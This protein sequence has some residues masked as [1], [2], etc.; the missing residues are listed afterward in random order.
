M[1]KKS[2]INILTF[3]VF[4]MTVNGQKV[5]NWSQGLTYDDFYHS[6]KLVRPKMRISN[7]TLYVCMASGMYFN[8]LQNSSSFFL[9]GFHELP[10]LDFA[11]YDNQLIVLPSRTTGQTD[12]LLLVSSNHGITFQDRTPSIEPKDSLLT[13]TGLGQNPLNPESLLLATNKGVYMSHDFGCKWTKCFDSIL[14]EPVLKYHPLDTTVIFLSGKSPKLNKAVINRINTSTGETSFYCMSENGSQITDL[15]FNAEDST[16]IW[17]ACNGKDPIGKSQDGG[18]TWQSSKSNAMV[19]LS[20][21]S[22]Y[23]RLWGSE[24][25][26]DT[27][28]TATGTSNSEVY[29]RRST[30]AGQN[31]DSL[32]YECFFLGTAITYPF[33]IVRYNQ[34]LFFYFNSGIYRLD[35]SKL[36]TETSNN[37]NEDLPILISPNPAQNHINIKTGGLVIDRLELWNMAGERVGLWHP[38]ES[39]YH[40]DVTNIPPGL[41][42]LEIRIGQIFNKNKIIIL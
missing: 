15:L 13:L 26:L 11:L 17:F 23:T 19:W 40:I 20:Q 37:K 9:Y 7:D 3:I 28:Y 31:W 38:K 33:D 8:D 14:D 22:H 32:Y 1:N 6:S 10:I 18:K 34:Y 2:A 39:T 5:E 24:S 4:S 16:E 35:L 29:V 42:L 41:Y 25:G 30:D 21:K 12:S 27:M 36:G